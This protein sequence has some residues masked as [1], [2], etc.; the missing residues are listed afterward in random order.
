L[1]EKNKVCAPAKNNTLVQDS[2]LFLLFMGQTHP[3]V[4]AVLEIYS[5]KKISGKTK[6][7]E[8]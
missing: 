4:G 2:Q 8:V 1:L 6:R 5:V 7:V 3:S